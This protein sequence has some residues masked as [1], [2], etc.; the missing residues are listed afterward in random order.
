MLKHSCLGT[1]CI[2]KSFSGSVEIREN[3]DL[4]DRKA[5]DN[6][7]KQMILSLDRW[8]YLYRASIPHWIW[9]YFDNN[10]IR[11]KK[12]IQTQSPNDKANIDFILYHKQTIFCSAK[13]KYQMWH[14]NFYT[15]LFIACINDRNPSFLRR[16]FKI[17]PENVYIWSSVRDLLA[18]TR[19]FIEMSTRECEQVN[20]WV[21]VAY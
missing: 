15:F 8:L 1:V 2:P 6:Q 17:S 21:S 12:K 18:C 3:M 11:D 16:V 10:L 9:I 5:L 14:F 13:K 4:Y 19:S 20:E 7:W